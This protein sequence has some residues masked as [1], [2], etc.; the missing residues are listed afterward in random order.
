MWK[1]PHL[2]FLVLCPKL[3]TGHS[4]FPSFDSLLR[5]FLRNLRLEFSVH[6]PVFADVRQ[7][8]PIANRKTGKVRSAQG[9]GLDAVGP[10]HLTIQDIALELH[11][12]IICTGTSVHFKTR[13]GNFRI[14]RR[15]SSI[16]NSYR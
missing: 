16:C 7:V 2:L 12:K 11:Q 15:R 9:G 8:L 5:F 1:I 14:F 6:S 4:F 10:L 13:N 3:C